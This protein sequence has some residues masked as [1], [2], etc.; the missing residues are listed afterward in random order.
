MSIENVFWLCIGMLTSAALAFV[1]PALLRSPALQHRPALRA[2][3]AAGFALLFV[4]ASVGLYQ[5]VGD[6]AS[7]ASTGTPAA[8]R[9]PPV[10]QNAAA[11]SLDAAIERLAARLRTDGGADA[12]WE[13]LAQS[14]AQSGNSPA[15]EAARQHRFTDAAAPAGATRQNDAARYRELVA[16]NPRDRAAWVALAQLERTARNLPAAKAALEKA[17]EL[18]AGEATVWADYA[19]VLASISGKLSGAPAKAIGKALALDGRHAK[20]LW[21]NASLALEEHRYP[22]AL[23]DWRRLREVVGDSSPDARIIDANIAET[24]SLTGAA[25]AAGTSPA[26]APARQVAIR[27]TVD[28]DPALKPRLKAGM[29]L[30][31]F[32]KAADAPGAPLAVM[33][34]QPTSWPVSFQLDDSM[35]MMPGRALSGF[36]EV[37]VEARLS[38]SGQA[39][40]QSGDLQAVGSTVRTGDTQRL[41]LR[42]SRVIS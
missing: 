29:T 5:V 20:A 1:L 25:G 3:V 34:V 38:V 31:V 7:L 30:F 37:V 11:G 19:D 15:A 16:K 8:T 41:A 4:V 23:R 27:G 33:R 13:L 36:D 39:T 42:I 24:L 14:Y 35:A 18:H 2:G 10:S 12:D 26:S 17:I 21:L 9:H 6:P 22:D 40:A 32:A 28:I